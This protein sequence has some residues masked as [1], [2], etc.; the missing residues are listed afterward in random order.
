MRKFY[1]FV[2]SVLFATLSVFAQFTDSPDVVPT[3]DESS[4]IWYKIGY[5]RNSGDQP[6]F[7]TEKG[8]DKSDVPV[9]AGEISGNDN[10]QLWQLVG[11]AG[12]FELVSKNGV[13]L[14]HPGSWPYYYVGGDAGRADWKGSFKLIPSRDGYTYDGIDCKTLEIVCDDGKGNFFFVDGKKFDASLNPTSYGTPIST[15]FV[16][17]KVDLANVAPEEK[18]FSL[19][20]ATNGSGTFKICKRGTTEE[21]ADLTKVPENTEIDIICEPA[22]GFVLKQINDGTQDYL[23]ASSFDPKTGFATT[24]SGLPAVTKNATI[25]VTF[26]EKVVVKQKFVLLRSYGSTP[27]GGV[28]KVYNSANNQEI[29]EGEK[30]EEGTTLYVKAIP[31]DGYVLKQVNIYGVSSSQGDL[32][33]DS[34]FDPKTGFDLT[35]NGINPITQNTRITVTFVKKQEDEVGGD[36]DVTTANG[37][38]NSPEVVASFDANA[39]KW[40][41]VAFIT[42]GSEDVKYLT[43]KGVDQRFTLESEIADSDDQLWQLVGDKDAGFELI[44][45]GGLYAYLSNYYFSGYATSQKGQWGQYLMKLKVSKN[46]KFKTLKTRQ[47]DLVNGGGNVLIPDGNKVSLGGE[48]NYYTQ[49]PINTSVLFKQ[50]GEEPKPVE[51]VSVTIQCEAYKG[52]VTIEGVTEAP[53]VSGNDNTWSLEAGKEY[54]L[55][56]VAKKGWD[57]S[58]IYDNRYANLEEKTF[59]ASKE[60]SRVEVHFKEKK[61][62]VAL[63]KKYEGGSVSV[64]NAFIEQL[65]LGFNVQLS[66]T[67]D[68]GYELESLTVRGQDIM[69]TKSFEIDEDNTIVAVFKKK[70]TGTLHTLTNEGGSVTFEGH[71]DGAEVKLGQEVNLV[72]TPTEG[73]E[74]ITLKVGGNDVKDSKKFVVSVDNTIEAVFQKKTYTLTAPSVMGGKLMFKDIKAGDKVEYG[75]PV[76]IEVV[77][78]TGYEL[79]T[80]TARGE[81]IMASKI[82]VVRDNNEIQASF[83]KKKY[84]LTL[85]TNDNGTVQFDGLENEAMVE[86][87]TEV[88]LVVTPKKG[89]ELE[90]LVVGGKD[91]TTDK[92]F[93]VGEDNAIVVRFKEKL[94]TLVAPTFEGGS[95]QFLGINAGDKLKL[96]TKVRVKVIPEKGYVLEKL[97]AGGKDITIDR[98]LTIDENNDV[99]AVF[100]KANALDEIDGFSFA[101][102]PNPATDYVV[103]EGLA[104]NAKVQVLDLTGKVVLTANAD[105]TGSLR[106]NVSHLPKGLYL[107]RSAKAVVK[108]QIR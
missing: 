95:I 13:H 77:P 35:V 40:Y 41:K 48:L 104:V 61:Y 16:F 14:Y 55:N 11:S 63:Y 69:A 9:V 57:F 107:V 73:Y 56:I 34:A 10:S 62:S 90:S 49:Q 36:D 38:T 2:L 60:N 7:I 94:Y 76:T 19:T 80:L 96:G 33:Q 75:T 27:Q 42:D 51:K 93:I 53:I 18:T 50:V 101:V 65:P 66:V 32:F 22:N 3:F 6:V 25:T 98:I 47:I 17:K 84:Q 70:T 4:K 102:Y 83:K 64:T 89:Y 45:K 39:T 86:F 43:S 68:A 100:R 92:K 81:D 44:S 74:L 1:L 21:I 23:D 37:F 20:K 72:V 105:F 79:A 12:S 29:L 82:F 108:L 78:E 15:S 28:F 99:V 71:Q 87:G 46:P 58:H 5:I 67:P 106:L 52:S 103:L 54:T 88:S 24:Y 97:T 59:T 31:E 85:P 26:A 30:V 8:K 91:I